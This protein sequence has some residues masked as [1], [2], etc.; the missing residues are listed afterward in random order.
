MLRFYYKTRHY[1]SRILHKGI[2]H[3]IKKSVVLVES[4]TSRVFNSAAVTRKLQVP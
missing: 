4:S 3:N 1:E 2:I